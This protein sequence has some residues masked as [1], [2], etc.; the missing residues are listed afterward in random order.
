MRELIEISERQR[1]AIREFF[2]IGIG[3]SAQILNEMFQSH[4]ILKI[5]DVRLISSAER[6]EGKGIEPDRA[7]SYVE[8]SFHGDLDG[9][10]FLLFNDQDLPVL[11]QPLIS[12]SVDSSS[13]SLIHSNVLLEIGNIVINSLV[14]SISNILQLSVFYTLPQFGSGPAGALDV[15]HQNGKENYS[16]FADTVFQFEKNKVNGFILLYMDLDRFETFFKTIQ[17]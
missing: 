10:A 2:N 3:K 7:V 6:Y 1:D 12:E 9:K 16:V 11:L 5:P 8:M 17:E 15:F 14:G 13:M 4:V